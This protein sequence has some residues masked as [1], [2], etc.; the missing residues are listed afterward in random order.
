MPSAGTVTINFAADNAAFLQGMKKN[1][2]AMRAFSQHI[3]AADASIKIYNRTTQKAAARF[4]NFHSAIGLVAGTAGLGRL[5]KR[6]SDLGA[7][8]VATSDRLGF[9]VEQLQKLRHAFASEGVAVNDA[10][11]GLQHFTR[12]LADAAQGNA[13]LQETFAQ[14]GVSITGADGKLRSSYDVLLDVAD[15]FQNVDEQS[16]RVRLAFA[17][18]GAQGVPFITALQQGGAAF[19]ALAERMAQFGLI[20]RDQAVRLKDLNQSFTDLGIVLQTSLAQA[21]AESSDSFRRLNE[22]AA[23]KLPAAM[24]VL[25]EIVAFLAR[26]IA[27]VSVVLVGIAAQILAMQLR[28]IG[29]A[30]AARLF[31]GALGVGLVVEFSDNV[32]RFF[33][34]L[35]TELEKGTSK[36]YAF[37]RAWEAAGGAQSIDAEGAEASQQ[38]SLS[39]GI[40]EIIAEQNAA[41]E[42]YRNQAN[43]IAQANANVGQSFSGLANTGKNSFQQMGQALG[44]FASDLIG[45]SQSMDDALRN[46][47]RS[48]LQTFANNFLGG[49]GGFNFGS[50]FGGIGQAQHGGY[51]YG[52]TIVGEKGPELVDFANP[53][54]VYPHD[55]LRSAARF[56]QRA[57][58]MTINYAPVIESDNEAAVE[59][60]LARS[61]P[62]FE[63]AVRNSVAQDLSRPSAM[64]KKVRGR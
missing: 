30:G 15:G 5:I 62:Q 58:G 3:K 38:H 51:H 47:A 12:I 43:Q 49:G 4:F 32:Q 64:R 55:V 23:E 14:L 56:G 13:K 61:Y 26:H 21:V 7:S 9:T 31:W 36:F 19:D 27:G 10:D 29:A 18:F 41:L 20:T 1:S 11:S 48:L 35:N 33:S 28:L 59:R 6:Q 37:V 8:L 34:T 54:R 25:V 63:E 42:N 22:Q 50:L 17:L 57:G 16:E 46:L 53:V 24:K 60:A 44:Q 52:P 40:A 39:K 2:A 45:K